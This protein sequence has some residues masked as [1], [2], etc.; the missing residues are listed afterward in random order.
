[1]R[2]TKWWKKIGNIPYD[3]FWK[4]SC[5]TQKLLHTWF[6]GQVSI[7]QKMYV[8]FQY[9]GWLIGIHIIVYELIQRKMGS[10]IPRI[11]QTIQASVSSTLIT[12]ES[13]ETHLSIQYLGKFKAPWRYGKYLPTL[14]W[15]T[16]RLNPS[17]TASP[18]VSS[19][20]SKGFKREKISSRELMYPTWAKGKSSTQKCRLVGDMLVLWRVPL[21][22]SIRWVLLK[23]F[24]KRFKCDHLLSSASQSVPPHF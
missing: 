22:Q 17:G 19:T 10:I 16:F 20:H 14:A 13:H 4:E 21:P 1:M 23:S 18:G 24:E 11:T 5:N 7:E 8:T 2:L 12:W 3:R 6:L 9:T 15:S